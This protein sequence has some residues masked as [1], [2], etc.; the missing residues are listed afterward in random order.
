MRRI[1]SQFSGTGAS[2]VRETRR[3]GKAKSVAVMAASAA[4]AIAAASGSAFAQ[5]Q[6]WNNPTG[7]AWDTTALSWNP[8]AD[9]TGTNAAWINGGSA[10]FSAGTALTGS[11][12]LTNAGVTVDN[13]TQEEGRFRVTAGTLTLADTAMSLDVQT[14]M[15]GDYDLK[16]DSIVADSTAGASSITKTGAGILL[17]SNSINTFSGGI[18][19]NAGTLAVEGS[20]ANQVQF[21]T[22]TLT[23]N[24]GAFVRSFASAGVA[25]NTANVLDVRGDVKVGA[26]QQNNG[27][28]RLTGAWAAGTTSGNFNVSNLAADY[29][30]FAPSSTSILVEG[31]IAAYTGTISHNTLAS[32]GNRLRFKANGSGNV[33]VDGSQARFALT[34]STTG[35]NCLDLADNTY[36]TFKMGELSGTGGRIRAGWGQL[37]TT[38]NTTWEVGALNT[39][40]TWAG[41]L[42]DNPQGSNAGGHSLL[43]KVGT[44][45]LTLTGSSAYTGLTTVSAGTLQIGNGG[46]TG[47]IANTASVVNDASL[48]FN[49]SDALTFAKVISGSGTVKQSG[50]GTLTLSAANTYSGATSVTAGTLAVTGSLANSAVTVG[51]AGTLGGTG[52]VKSAALSGG[53]SA[54]SLANS[55]Q[56]VLTLMQGGTIGGASQLTFDIGSFGTDKL[57]IGTGGTLAVSGSPST[58]NL[59]DLS[60]AVAGT[61]DLITFDSGAATGLSNLTL[62]NSIFGFS[63]TLSTTPTALRLVVVSLPSAPVAYW[64]GDLST[65]WTASSGANTNWATTA[66]LATEL[67]QL[68]GTTTEVNFNH[69][70]SNLS[71]TLGSDVAIG[72]L[73][74]GKDS[75]NTAPV[76]I[77]GAN[78]LGL[79]G[80]GGIVVTGGSASNDISVATLQVNTVVPLRN[81]SGGT[82]SI[83]S[84]ITGAGGF[85]LNGTGKVLL[86]G[87]NTFTGGLTITNGTLQ[88][89][90]AT[91]LG[92]GS[93]LLNSG[94]LDVNG[95]NLIVPS[96]FSGA[97][98]TITNSTGAST[99]TLN[100]GTIASAIADGAGTIGLINAGGTLVLNGS[101]SYSGGTTI[102]G[103]SVR[104]A[105]DAA[106]G[107]AAGAVTLNAGTL[108]STGTFTMSRPIVVNNAA[109]TLSVA[110]TQTLTYTGSM[111]GT[112][113]LTKSGTGTLEL[114]G[115]NLLWDGTFALNA[116][117][118]KLVDFNALG[119]TIGKSRISGGSMDLNGMFVLDYFTA[120]NG[121]GAAGNGALY[122]SSATPAFVLGEIGAT[123]ANPGSFTVGAG[124]ISLDRVVSNGAITVTKIGSGSL[125]F[126]GSLVNTN[127][128]ATVNSGTLVLAKTGVN[129]I[130]SSLTA[131]AGG[132]VQLAGSSDDQILNSVTVSINGGTLDMN[133]HAETIGALSGISSG[134][135]TNTAAST[136]STLTLGGNN[137]SG[138]F[139]G[140]ISNGA[141]TVGLT[142][143]GTGTQALTGA[144]TYTGP[145][146]ING[147]ALVVNGSLAGTGAVNLVT[148]S[149][150]PQ[151]RG[152]GTVGA[153]TLSADNASN[154]AK[155]A[156]GA[157]GD[158][159][160]GTLKTTGLTTNGGNL[161]FDLFTPAT[162]DKLQVNGA[163]NFAGA[164]AITLG[165]APQTGTFTLVDSTLPIT[166]GVAPTLVTPSDPNARPGSSFT[167]NT[168]NPNK[169]QVAVVS[170]ALDLQWT[171]ANSGDWDLNTTANF[172]SV[173]PEQFYTFDRV[174]FGNGPANRNV[175]IIGT[176]NPGS[177]TVNNDASNDY[178]LT[179]A[180]S[181]AGAGTVLTKS[182][183]GALTIAN[184]TANTYAG[185]TVLNAGTLN[186]NVAGALGAGLLTLNG[187][188][189]GNTTAAAVTLT[190]NNAQSWNGNFAFAGPQN[191]NLGSGAV[192][193]N[194]APTV[195]V[196]GTSTLTVAGP[197]GDGSGTTFTKAGTG[198]L[199][200]SNGSSSFTGDLQ[201]NGGTVNVTV[202]AANDGITGPLGRVSIPTRSIVVN[203]GGTLLMSVNNVFGA[204]GNL[205]ISKLA[206][207][208]G[209]VNATRY[210]TLGDVTLNGGTLT[211]TSTDSGNY[212]GYQLR[213]SVTVTGSTPSMITTTNGRGTHLAANTLFTVADA[214]ASAAADL[215]ISTPLV[216]QSGDFSNS[217]GGLTKGGAGT[218]VSTGANIYTGGTTITDGTLQLGKDAFQPIMGGAT[219]TVPL[220]VDIQKG[221]LVFDY[222]GGGTDPAATIKSSLQAGYTSGFSTGLLRSST[223]NSTKGLGWIDNTTDSTVTV[224]YTYYGDFNLDMKVNFSDLLVLAANYG[225]SPATGWA[226]GDA[227]YD[228]VVNFTDLLSL[229]ANYGSTLS[230]SFS[231]DWALAQSFVGS[232]VPEPTVLGVLGAAAV[233]SLRRRRW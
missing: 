18:T 76:S 153:V 230:G 117:T 50:V 205:T 80:S 29:N 141:G 3:A 33:V 88:L 151:L 116:G 111:S 175:A 100:G 186:L 204:A 191:L 90:S 24:G 108:E 54:I 92:A 93:V 115:D 177:V 9:G 225:S 179:G 63:T 149:A 27:N 22:G 130:G 194:G 8:L 170:A 46:T 172:Q 60:G 85:N 66:S 70:T 233:L 30:G 216:N 17:F 118:V 132:T 221:K 36:G 167:A 44:G 106:L 187:G 188:T 104:V 228:S 161:S 142:K 160:V 226:A 133:G 71:T 157:D 166:Y 28:W 176:L 124:D 144:N 75:V 202:A 64:S 143:T 16:I 1:E 184:T 14:R 148:T 45:T 31:D 11:Y 6:Y 138:S 84:A 182:G 62:G 58:I 165:G 25:I 13:I 163:V 49:R 94:T 127:V 181:I 4:V 174:T 224:A 15:S 169:Y 95:Q 101:N 208:G 199:T 79:F 119:T 57:A 78:K 107:A 196:S 83:S 137:A 41:N 197:I 210:N 214:T 223:A 61:Y 139:A 146:E 43:T 114:S 218:L 198:T 21:G 217:P 38:G 222:S 109:S 213:G 183:S 26:I 5:I 231:G 227:N 171:G 189:L 103:G 74:F 131:N 40:T 77:G 72:S 126:T 232:T 67:G 134:S 192:T 162:S 2:Q 47:S 212:L 206:I 56:S 185:G 158:N 121:T 229:A 23:L 35:A 113:T 203:S 200:L 34:G 73:V 65:V 150:A 180:G 20:N 145:T 209:T 105:V 10:V 201:I 59:V 37:T 7:T 68:P 123:N 147:G 52:S 98:G 136:T 219:V 102:N 91:A 112:G 193:L 39:S 69:I 86:G 129:A 173:G 215:T 96:G 140:V 110:G 53:G 55:A 19:L 42:D 190:T 154:I 12:T 128:G 81:N 152:T 156:P 155:V 89:G 135:V 99:L 207:N 120:I 178:S 48:V 211:Q 87:A 51:S 168:S 122:N 195:T 125:S 82:L 159:S 220:G 32:G 97:G 164:T